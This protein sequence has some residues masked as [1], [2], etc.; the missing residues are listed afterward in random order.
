MSTCLLP[1]HWFFFSTRWYSWNMSLS[2]AR[3]GCRITSAPVGYAD[4]VAMG[5]RNLQ[6]AISLFVTFMPNVPN[7]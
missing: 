4:N 6:F 1:S 3:V 5:I 7:S 2:A